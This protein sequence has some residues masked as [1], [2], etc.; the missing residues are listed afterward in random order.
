MIVVDVPQHGGPE[1]LT[2]VERP[3]PVPAPGELLVRVHAAGVDRPDLMQRAG[4][5]P[6]PPGAPTVRASKWRARSRPWGKACGLAGGPGCVRVAHWGRLCRVRD[7]PGGPVHAR[8]QGAGH[9]KGRR[10]ARGRFHMLERSARARAAPGR[11]VPAGAWGNEWRG[12][13]RAPMGSPAW[14]ARVCDGWQPGKVRVRDLGPELA[15]DYKRRTS[16]PK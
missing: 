11:R 1:V 10:T 15:I 4:I 6:M 12:F 8:A 9:A 3:I 2:V 14:R 5:Y 16:S 7:R 13:A